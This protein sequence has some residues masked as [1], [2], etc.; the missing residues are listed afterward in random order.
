MYVDQ[1]RRISTDLR[2]IWE[3]TKVL[4]EVTR[5][6][7]SRGFT[8]I[9]KKLTSWLPNSTWLR[10]LFV[11]VI[12]VVCVCILACIMIQF[13]NCCSQMC[14]K[15]RYDIIWNFGLLGL[16]ESYIFWRFMIIFVHLAWQGVLWNL[17]TTKLMAVDQ[18]CVWGVILVWKALMT[19]R[20]CKRHGESKPAVTTHAHR[21][22]QVKDTLEQ[23]PATP[24]TTRDPHR[25]PQSTCVI[26]IIYYN[27]L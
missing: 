18:V 7:T 12:T 15:V 19:G 1:S 2:W 26:I 16:G 20:L 6:D 13:C 5:D 10:N 22:V 21:K 14:L 25:R 27:V 3:Q 23:P 17:G 8:D 11:V 9:W 24:K 4:Q